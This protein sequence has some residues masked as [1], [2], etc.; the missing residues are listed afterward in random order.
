M[1]I[2]FLN[3]LYGQLKEPLREFLNKHV[4]NTDV[5]CFQESSEPFLEIA[6]PILKDFESKTVHKLVSSGDDFYQT[7][8]VNKKFEMKNYKTI[9]E[10]EDDMGLTNMAE[11]GNIHFINVHGVC[12]P[13]DKMDSPKRLEQS[14][15]IID[16]A[17]GLAI[18]GGDFNLMPNTES[19]EMFK[20]SGYL[21]LIKKYG[22]KATRN[23]FAWKK[24][25][26]HELYFCDY[27]FVSPEIKVKSFEVP[28]MTISD[29]LPMILEIE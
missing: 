16:E 8:F 19:I 9:F 12:R 11:V 7:I 27:V 17:K 29:H 1:K 26:G 5:F 24:Y 3:V 14:K 28:E 25:P 20:K 15:R 22:I 23:E 4:K 2:I 10:G 13:G 6:R 18:I 21:D